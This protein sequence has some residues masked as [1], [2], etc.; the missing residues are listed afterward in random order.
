M[1]TQIIQIL[2][3]SLLMISC[4]EKKASVDSVVDPET[5]A[6]ESAVS[7]ISGMADDQAGSSYAIISEGWK[8]QALLPAAF[9]SGCSRAVYNTCSSG[10][11]SET[12]LN[13]NPGLSNF[14]LNGN[15]TLTYNN[16]IC[17]M[18]TLGA[19]VTRTYNVK[20]SG[21]RG[22]ELSI[23]SNSKSDY[24]GNTY[25]GGGKITVTNTGWNL[26]I[27]GKHKV[28]SFKEKTLYDVSTRTV[29]PLVITGSLARASR[30]INAGELQVNHNKAAF[31][32]LFSPQNLQWSN[33]C[34]HPISGSLNV[35]WSGTKTGTATVSFQ[36]C[37][38]AQV[39]ENGQT[40][41]IELSYCE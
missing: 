34:C 8:Q 31:S 37:G 2:A 23:S 15:V 28:L 14:S 17:D 10:V 27:L 21:P 12:Y 3:L 13:C 38:Q 36:G 11:K 33:S 30:N 1:K 26:D 19:N 41:D 25:G 16:S 6:I 32:A 35:V 24:T 39:N 20:I 29:T 5:A 40:K 4:A 7:L 22:G 18:N 9:A